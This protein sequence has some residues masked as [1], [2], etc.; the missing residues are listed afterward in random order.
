MQTCDL[1]PPEG[2]S[3]NS[4]NNCPLEVL[5]SCADISRSSKQPDHMQVTLISDIWGQVRWIILRVPKNRLCLRGI[6]TLYK[7]RLGSDLGHYFSSRSAREGKRCPVS[8]Q[9]FC[10]DDIFLFVTVVTWH[11]LQLLTVPPVQCWSFRAGTGYIYKCTRLPVHSSHPCWFPLLPSLSLLELLSSLAPAPA[12][13]TEG[14][15]SPRSAPTQCS[16]EGASISLTLE[17]MAWMKL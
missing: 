8:M 16:M 2:H 3:Q 1:I 6:W 14:A 13:T 7:T 10:F 5:F 11:I 15:G 12:R 4:S 9:T 17:D